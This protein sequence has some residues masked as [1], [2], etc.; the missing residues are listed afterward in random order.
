MIIKIGEYLPEGKL[1]EL[2]KTEGCTFSPKVFNVSDL[3]KDKKIALIA[4]PGA[5]TPTC[6]ASHLPGYIKQASK[7][8]S[9]GIDEIWILSVNDVFVM[10]A[11]GD[12]QNATGIVRLLSDG[13]GDFI[14]TLG[15]DTDLTKFGMGVRSKRFS[16]IIDDGLVKNLNIEVNGEFKVSDAETLLSQLI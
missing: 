6:S 4:V 11:W 8:K 15:L 10:N 7:F 12:S 5:F 3:V 2:I 13:N 1:S 16:A 14:K 9:K